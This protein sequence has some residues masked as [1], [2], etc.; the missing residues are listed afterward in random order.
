MPF[1][2][3]NSPAEG[4]TYSPANGP[5]YIFQNGVWKQ[6]LGGQSPVLTAQSRNRIV[7]GAFQI[8]QENGTSGVVSGGYPVDQWVFSSSLPTTGA[9]KTVAATDSGGGQVGLQVVT[10]KP[11]LAAGD[12][13]QFMQRIEGNRISDFKWGGASAKQVILR[14]RAYTNAPGTYT[15]SLSNSAQNRVFLAPF[16]LPNNAWTEIVIVVPGDTTGT[17]LTDTN[18]GV[19]VNFGLAA[20]T[21]YGGGSAGWGTANKIQIAGNTNG[22]AT[23]NNT[24][25]IRDVGLYLDPD[26]TG[27]APPWQ[28]PDEAEELTTCERYWQKFPGLV[29][30]TAALSQSISF[31]PMRVAP[32]VSNPTANPG[33][34]SGAIYPN[35]GH[36][37]AT[38]RNYAA[39]V[40]NAR[41]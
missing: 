22:A 41:M 24:F 29:A 19:L 8:S 13:W 26:N 6:V 33:F 25:Y 15:V 16:T 36:F 35:C 32:V 18:T 12:Y 4:A 1:D 23:A 10:P 7:N 2:F 3:P 27:L 21:T 9:S 37:Y 14:F 28:M 11:S 39:V 31:T 5:Q 38:T 40:L 30:E 17:W 34:G 20:G